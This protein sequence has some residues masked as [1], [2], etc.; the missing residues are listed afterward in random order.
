M[1]FPLNTYPFYQK[2]SFIYLKSL[3]KICTVKRTTKSRFLWEYYM[4]NPYPAFV[5]SQ[6]CRSYSETEN[7]LF[8]VKL[9]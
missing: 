9:A 1:S 8:P 5:P 6:S 4:G 7:I 2:P 3:L